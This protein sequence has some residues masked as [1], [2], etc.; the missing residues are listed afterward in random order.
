MTPE[1]EEEYIKKESE[2]RERIRDGICK[3]HHII[4]RARCS[5]GTNGCMENHEG[6]K[7]SKEFE[8]ILMRAFEFLESRSDW[9][10]GHI[11]E[12][13]TV[14]PSDAAYWFRLGYLEALRQAKKELD[15]NG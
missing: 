12:F 11:P 7:V 3:P 5:L 6:E 13:S 8:L 10:A 1:Q 9:Y 4:S 2:L 14:E 15:K